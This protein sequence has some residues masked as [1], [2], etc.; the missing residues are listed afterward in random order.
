MR[1]SSKR[2]GSTTGAAGSFSNTQSRAYITCY[3][4][5]ATLHFNDPTA[6]KNQVA[7]F[8][9]NSGQ[10]F[11]YVESRRVHAHGAYG[12]W[13]HLVRSRDADRTCL[14][15]FVEF[16]SDAAKLHSH[17]TDETCDTAVRLRDCSGRRSLDDAESFLKG[18]KIVPPGYNRGVAGG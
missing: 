10:T 6:S 8:Y 5:R 18:M 1:W 7:K 4:L 11:D 2:R 9:Q 14:F 15:A 12:G 13:V 16:L 3:N 17:V